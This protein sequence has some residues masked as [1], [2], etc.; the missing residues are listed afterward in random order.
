MET[1]LEFLL[2]FLTHNL[3][4]LFTLPLHLVLA[5][6]SWEV[7]TLTYDKLRC[8]CNQDTLKIHLAEAT[9]PPLT[10]KATFGNIKFKF[11]W[12]LYTKC[13]YNKMVGICYMKKRVIS[14]QALE[15]LDFQV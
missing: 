6:S 5:L 7:Q 12:E 8:K 13:K 3:S 10:A 4:N 2:W 14:A 15:T 11:S 9:A 1:C